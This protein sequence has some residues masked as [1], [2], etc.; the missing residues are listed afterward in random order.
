MMESRTSLPINTITNCFS[1]IN[2]LSCFPSRFRRLSFESKR[3]CVTEAYNTSAIGQ[4][5]PTGTTPINDRRTQMNRIAMLPIAMLFT[6][7]VYGAC[8]P[9]T[10]EIGDTGPGHRVICETL[11]SQYPDSDIRILNREIHSAD[12]VSVLIEVDGHPQRVEYRLSGFRWDR[13]DSGLLANQ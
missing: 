8:L 9:G 1:D 10:M 4:F 2:F 11:S 12:R 5:G 3:E 6:S 7:T 13:E